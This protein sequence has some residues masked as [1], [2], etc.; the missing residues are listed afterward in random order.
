MHDG[1]LPAERRLTSRRIFTGKVVSLE[2]DQVSLHSGDTTEREVVRHRGAV[3]LLPL[4]EDGS[5]VFV[6]QYR[7]AIGRTL[8]ELPAGKLEPGED[9]AECARRELAEETGWA[10][11]ELHRLG[12]LYTTPGFSDEL[13]HAFVAT[14]LQPAGPTT[15]DPDELLQVV[16]LSPA[17]IHRHTATGDLCDGK[18]LTVLYQAS[19]AGWL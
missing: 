10:A 2:V 6:R 15:P 12:S 19:V 3:V 17:E 18:S 4:L 14:D 1:E 16:P 9:P 5:V 7:Y 13:L 8:L 11:G